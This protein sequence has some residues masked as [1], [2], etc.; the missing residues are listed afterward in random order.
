MLF[1]QI[2]NFMLRTI[3]C[4]VSIW[5]DS[6]FLLPIIIYIYMGKNYWFE[7]IKKIYDKTAKNDEFP[8]KRERYS[9]DYDDYYYWFYRLVFYFYAVLFLRWTFLQILYHIAHNFLQERKRI[10][11][12]EAFLYDLL[13]LIIYQFKPCWS[14]LSIKGL[15]FISK[16]K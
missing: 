7:T 11:E 6:L 9:C 12:I 5:A 13:Q 14:P 4:Y 3:V 8:E 16:K 15:V 10:L 2:I 1:Y